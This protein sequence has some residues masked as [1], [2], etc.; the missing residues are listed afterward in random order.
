MLK[1]NHTEDQ[2]FWISY[3]DLMAGL[4]FVF[5]LVVGAI[6]VKSELIQS[7][8]QTIRADLEKEKEALHMSEESLSQKKK[9]LSKIQEE[10]LSARAENTHLS[11]QISLLESQTAKLNDTIVLLSADISQKAE[12]L[13]LSETEMQSLKA[14]LLENENNIET[15]TYSNQSLMSDLNNSKAEIQQLQSFVTDYNRRHTLDSNM[16]QLR[17]DEIVQLEKALLI[18]KR[19]YQ[20]VVEDL[21]ITRTKIKNLTGIKIKVVQRLKEK[22]GDSINIDPKSGALR[23]SSNILF[24]QGEA[25]LKAEAKKELSRILGT[26]I[27]ALLNDKQMRQYIDTIT[28]EGHTNSDGSYLYNL[29]LSQQRALAVMSFL[30][31]EYPKNRK[32]FE[33]YLN[34]SGRS[35]SEPILKDSIEDKDASRRIEIKFRIKNEEAVKELMNY[36]NKEELNNA[37]Q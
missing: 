15:L 24:N 1:R 2:N 32:L 23:F 11:L 10:L 3:A 18:K 37:K 26:Y 35:F 22:M 29:N 19:A 33:K 13:A 17:D 30:Y 16:I 34:A 4:L 12:S 8:L 9:K 20:Q 6:V 14:L 27:D 25:I 28:I 21:N 7:D 31:E 5:I 36:L